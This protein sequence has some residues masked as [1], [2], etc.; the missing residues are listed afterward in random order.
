MRHQ[1]SIKRGKGDIE[2]DD[3]DKSSSSSEMLAMEVAW[4]R[5]EQRATEEHVAAMWRRV[6]DTERR[7][8]QMLSILLRVVGDPDVLRRLAGSSGSGQGEGAEV[9]RPRLLLDSDGGSTVV[10]QRSGNDQSRRRPLVPSEAWTCTSRWQRV[11]RRR[12][13]APAYGF[14]MDSHDRF[15]AGPPV[16]VYVCR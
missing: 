4:L 14:H 6:Q 3:E 12:W 10:D 15:D 1:S 2:D 5:N 16:P 7:P 8:K 13:T 9:K 11:R